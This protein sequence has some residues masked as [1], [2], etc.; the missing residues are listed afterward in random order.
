MRAIR[1]IKPGQM[2]IAP[3]EI[4]TPTPDWFLSQTGKAE[5]KLLA[6]ADDGL[7]WGKVEN[8]KVTLSGNNFPEF[9]PQ[10]RPET[11]EEA[12]LFNNQSEVYLWRTDDGWQARRITD[13]SG[14]IVDYYDE[15]HILWGNTHQGVKGGFTA[16]SDGALGFR[17]AIPVEVT[18]DKFSNNRRP[19][20][21]KVRHY[22][23][24]DEN[25]GVMIV[26]LSRLVNVEVE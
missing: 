11:L 14:E 13:G 12:R 19:L 9:S 16:V 17:H 26:T 4:E 3:V 24:Q 6:F 10:L 25:T 7:I 8:G 5:C 23:T 18:K 15:K 21:L 22:L 2:I 1:E 20:R